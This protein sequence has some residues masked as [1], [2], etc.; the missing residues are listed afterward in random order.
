MEATDCAWRSLKEEFAIA[1]EVFVGQVSKV[2]SLTSLWDFYDPAPPQDVIA[3]LIGQ[4][5]HRLYRAT[6]EVRSIWKGSS[7]AIRY[8][9][10]DPDKWTARHFAQGR[11]YLVY[12]YQ[13]PKDGV[14]QTGVCSR[15]REI[16]S[17]TD[18]LE[19]LGPPLH[20]FGK[21]SSCQDCA[22]ARAAWLATRSTQQTPPQLPPLPVARS[23]ADFVT[24]R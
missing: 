16:G 20:D 17:A 19:L 7:E 21:P 5:Q 18:D 14:L 24:V 8:L 6:F 10:T 22:N 12:A 4:G 23:L 15:T 2:E 1:H 3:L 11:V 9:R 13:T